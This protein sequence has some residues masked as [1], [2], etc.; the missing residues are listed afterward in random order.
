MEC[1]ATDISESKTVKNIF[2]YIPG[3]K[4]V[5]YYCFSGI[6]FKKGIYTV[7]VSVFIKPEITIN[8]CVYMLSIYLDVYIYLFL[9]LKGERKCNR[10]A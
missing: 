1:N 2:I 9:Q 10:A 4:S 3:S 7:I 8:F 5:A 6:I